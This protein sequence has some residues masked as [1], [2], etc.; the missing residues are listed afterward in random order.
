MKKYLTRPYNLIFYFLTILTCCLEVM[1]L[2]SVLGLEIT[3]FIAVVI[4]FTK[5]LFLLSKDWKVFI[6]LAF[7]M[8]FSIQKPFLVLINK[9]DNTNTL[10]YIQSNIDR[11]ELEYKSLIAQYDSSKKVYDKAQKDGAWGILREYDKSNRLGELR[12]EI[13]FTKKEISKL[14]LEKLTFTKELENWYKSLL[15]LLVILVA[16][17]IL[18]MAASKFVRMRKPGRPKN[19]KNKENK[20]NKENSKIRVKRKYTRRKASNNNGNNGDVVNLND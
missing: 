16:E 9:T 11:T 2:Y 3:I 1:G 15:R 17:F 13:N 7:S 19:S 8:F 4:S 5:A 18:F 14:E 10:Q 12:N 6:V 20:E